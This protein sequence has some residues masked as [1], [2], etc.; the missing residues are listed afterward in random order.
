M[1]LSTAGRRARA[2][3]TVLLTAAALALPS[4]APAQASRADRPGNA[5]A[6]VERA[7]E[8][9]G[10]AAR[11]AAVRTVR[12]ESIGHS[13][14]I[15]QSERPEGPF[16]A[17]YAQTTERRDHEHGRWRT[18][19][20]SRWIQVPE[21]RGGALVVA[22]GVAARAFGS[23]VRPGSQADVANAARAL[24]LAPERVLLT[25]LAAPDLAL[26]PDVEL[27]GYVQHVVNFTHGDATI[28]VILNPGTWLPTGVEVVAD[29]PLG[30]WG[31]V[32][33]TTLFSM[34]TIE[35]GLRFPRQTDRFWNGTPRGSETVTAVSLDASS[36]PDAFAIPDEVREA[37]DPSPPPRVASLTLGQRGDGP[38][39]VAP[40]V[41]QLTGAW[42]VALVEQ[43]DGIVI[44]EA[45]I[46]SAYSAQVL[47]EAARRYPGRPI[48]A[49]VTTSDAWPHLGGVREYVAR[50]IPVYALD[51]NRPILERLLAARHR[52]EPDRLEREPRAPAFRWVSDRTVVGEGPNRLEL[53][54][55]RGENG[56]RMIMAWLPERR[57]L[58]TSD[59][60]QRM[61]DGSFFMPMYL[62]EIE[63]AAARE[64]LAVERVFGMHLAPT[65]WSDVTAAVRAAEAGGGR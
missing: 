32:T 64:G 2:T 62:S 28:R 9:M 18:E 6:M 5:R 1:P 50:G 63:A 42:S 40:G 57:V 55:V 30:I 37:F 49:V 16:I 12:T 27:Q 43:A 46:S 20:Q 44:I 23:A 14:A 11:L 7:I 47:D 34:W 29:D 48:T 25:A 10:G 33:E 19:S 41:V 56:E 61:P 59:E 58:Y 24:A 8:A 39:D 60:A 26:A 4:P 21:W 51:L 36:P 45:P 22:D 38:K 3:L 17:M 15:E 52:A 13:Y 53:Y 31:D 54:P 35:Q 65:P